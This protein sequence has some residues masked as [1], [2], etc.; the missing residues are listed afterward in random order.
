MHLGIPSCDSALIIQPKPLMQTS[1]RKLFLLTFLFCAVFALAASAQPTVVSADP[2]GDYHSVK[3][4]YSTIMDGASATNTAN[5]A[6]VRTSD[7]AAVTIASATMDAT[8]TNVVLHIS[9]SFGVTTNYTLTISNVKDAGLNTLT[10]NPTVVSFYFGGPPGGLSFT[11]DNGQVPN[12]TFLASAYPAGLDTF[13]GNNPTNVYQIITNVGGFNNS[14]CL[15][16]VSNVTGQTF[17]QWH[18]TNVYTLAGNQPVTNFNVKFK[19]WMVNLDPG[20]S[21]TANT[22]GNGLVFHV[23]PEIPQQYTGGGSSW[24]NG[25]DL[26]FRNF[27]NGIVPQGVNIWWYPPYTEPNTVAWMRNQDGA[28][29][30]FTIPSALPFPAGMQ[31]YST[32]W[33]HAN[34]TVVNAYVDTNGISGGTT[35]FS[36]YMNVDF[37]VSNGVANLTCS[38]AN[39]G[40]VPLFVNQ[41]I[42]TW[43]PIIGGSPGSGL[44]AS[45]DFTATDGAGNHQMVVIDDLDLTLNGV[46]IPGSGITTNVLGDVQLVTQPVSVTTNENVYVNFS[47]SASGAPPYSWQWYSNNIAIPGANSPTYRTPLTLYSNTINGVVN[48]SVT[49]SNDFSYATSS[50]A[51]LTLIKD[52]SGVQVVSVGSVDGNSI[53]IQFSSFV[54]VA[55]AGNPA[56][57]LVN[58]GAVSVTAAT[59]RSAR[60]RS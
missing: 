21:L 60:A 51:V 45:F 3:V 26:N 6:L 42:A 58:G 39:V 14:G 47:A 24:G 8:E 1:S 30:G 54:D 23:G 12:D 36:N 2:R 46:H 37:S 20:F 13:N 10:P 34:S 29:Q 41:T 31:V 49:V 33:I 48:Y 57:Y 32:N 44:P 43:T 28:G 55:T 4:V 38:N 25:L 40:S 5:Y 56:N 59:V 27:A 7:S 53:G 16:V 35:G 52:T 50:N 11:F 19:F 15:T 18:L 22:I 17:G 9:G